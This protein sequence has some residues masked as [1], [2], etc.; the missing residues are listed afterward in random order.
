[1]GLRGLLISIG[2]A[3]LVGAG[4]AGCGGGSDGES[5]EEIL[6]GLQKAVQTGKPYAAVRR[7]EDLKA[8]ERASADAFCE[9]N[10]QML[11]N[12]EMEKIYKT[13]YYISRIKLRAERELPFVSTQPVNVAVN[14]LNEL[15]DLSSF[16]VNSVT[17]YARACYR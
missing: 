9:T 4:F 1:M 12:K 13:K 15:L 14:K 5:Y 2:I 6:L 7:A 8:T 3:V 16:D 11:L 17:R 10:Q